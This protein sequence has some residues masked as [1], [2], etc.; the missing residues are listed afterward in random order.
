MINKK[1]FFSLF[2]ISPYKIIDYNGL[3]MNENYH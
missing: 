2:Y 3:G 1:E